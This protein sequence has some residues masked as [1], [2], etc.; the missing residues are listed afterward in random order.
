MPADLEL[1][2]GAAQKTAGSRQ[3]FAFD[4]GNIPQLIAGYTIVGTPVVTALPSGLTISGIQLDYPYQV[5]AL[6]SG[7]TADVDYTVTWA[8]TLSDP[9]ATVISR[10]ATLSVVNG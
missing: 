4:F 10:K 8:I 3:R 5:S 2:T 7:G 1:V 9:D 6:F